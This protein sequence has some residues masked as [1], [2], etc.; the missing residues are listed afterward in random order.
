M[1]KHFALGVLLGG[2]GLGGLGFGGLGCSRLPEYAAP[3]QGNIAIEDA[4]AGD[5]IPYRKLTREDF[6]GKEVPEAFA[7]VAEQVGAATCARIV[8]DPP[9]QI[10]IRS[11]TT[12]QGETTHTATI[13]SVSYRALMDRGCSWWNNKASAQNPE[14]VLEHEQIHFALFEIEAR[15][16]HGAAQELKEELK[17]TASTQAEAQQAVEEAIQE[18]FDETT[19]RLLSRNRDLDEDTSLGYE[20]ARQKEWV[21]DIEEELAETEK[22]KAP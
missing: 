13:K 11:L 19:A 6:R 9:A 15:R 18:L 4:L 16:L 20:P 12:P 2:L 22:F 1:L 17:V 7:A 21:A 5:L 3:K 14:Y 8:S 10:Q